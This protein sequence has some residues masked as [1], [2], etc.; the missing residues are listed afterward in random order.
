VQA[1]SEVRAADESV[2]STE[3]ALASIRLSAQQAAE[4]LRITNV[5]FEAGA[6]TN[7]EVI[8][9]QRSARDAESAV[10]IATDCQPARTPRPAHRAWSLSAAVVRAVPAVRA[11][12][13]CDSC[14]PG[15]RMTRSARL[16][17]ASPS[18]RTACIAL[19][20]LIVT[21][22][23]AQPWRLVAQAPE[24]AKGVKY[25][26]ISPADMKEWLTYL[27]SDELQGRQIFTEGYGLAAAYV[28]DRL[29][30]WKVKPL[31][32]DGTYFQP[33]KLNGYKSTRN[34]SITITASGESKTFKHG[35]HVTFPA[36]AGG[37]QTGHVHRR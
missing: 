11:G 12:Y 35:D 6:T 14:F 36:N 34:S 20:L 23:L 7:L 32:A 5:A 8:D 15:G 37:K 24:P 25:A 3:R 31:G 19:V 17:S 27:A 28:A 10:A 16:S 1:R 9:A 13:A 4:V 29:K 33:V 21:S 2:K 30:E 18:A 22:G 26:Q